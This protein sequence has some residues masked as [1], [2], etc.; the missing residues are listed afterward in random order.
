[1]SRWDA[2]LDRVRAAVD[3]GRHAAADSLLAAFAMTGGDTAAVAES[4][5]WR[6]LLKA[7]PAN[8]TTAPGEARAALDAYLAQPGAAR[9]VEAGVVRRL[10]ALADSLRAAQAGLRAANEL[11]ERTKD[12][13]IA[14]LRDE[15][16]R[17]QAE[18]ERIKR[19]LGNP[20]P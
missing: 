17:T 14:K 20:K 9:R 16:Q 19:R 3:S 5:L 1:M 2:T 4:V 18:L 6:L 8:Q 12:E 10:L 13:E 11:R 7:D 15:L